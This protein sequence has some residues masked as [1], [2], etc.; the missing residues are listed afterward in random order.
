MGWGLGAGD[1]GTG[2]LE[3]GDEGLEWGLGVG[4]WVF[5]PVPAPS[6][7]PLPPKLSGDGGGDLGERAG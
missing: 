2:E 7:Q 4:I 6:P 3:A 1:W 5:S